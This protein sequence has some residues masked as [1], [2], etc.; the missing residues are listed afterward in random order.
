[1]S[2]FINCPFDEIYR[3]CFEAILVKVTLSG[4]RVRCA[5]EDDD[6]GD[7]RF[8][9]LCDLI[10]ESDWSI[11]D[12]SRTTTGAD[13]LPRFNMPF[14]LGLTMGAR[15]FGKG[16]QAG[17]K[18]AIMV[19]EPFVMPRF[20]SDLAGNDPKPHHGD[21]RRIIRIVRDHL[22]TDP[23]G[24]L[25]PGAAHMAEMLDTYRRLLPELAAA[26]QLTA[27]E[28]HPYRGYRNF[29]D[30]LRGFRDTLRA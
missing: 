18:A 25:L 11:H 26:A 13:G 28:V 4:Y 30:L 24:A 29:M 27:E 10:A 3:P 21:P 22:H 5:L 20:L 23:G 19:A 15:R 14:E 9:K 1:V 7:V 8:D 2:V 6:A 17:K 16:R 12:L